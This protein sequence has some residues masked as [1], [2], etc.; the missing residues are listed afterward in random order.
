M[1]SI[2][3]MLA[4]SAALLLSSISYATIVEIQTDLGSFQVNLYDQNTPIT[5]D[6]FLAYVDSSAYSNSVIHRSVPGFVVQGGGFA[7]TEFPLMG[8]ESL[9]PITNEPVYSNVRGT[10]AMAKVSGQPNSATTQW[11]VNLEDNSATLDPQNGG[12]TVFGQVIS[13]MDVVDAIAALD[14]HNFGGT[15]AETPTVNYT[16]T[17]ADGNPI[18][19]TIE[20]LVFVNAVIIIDSAED[21]AANLN[22]A[23][24]VL[25]EEEPAASDDSSGSFSWLL[26]GLLACFRRK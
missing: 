14:V 10:I 23:L 2:K 1:T 7:G 9:G 15:F 16:A 17:D 26:L 3:R 6:N 8:I 4:T 19:P 18:N 5:V 25:I 24:N 22:P 21:T 20:N 12:F 13:G 11:F